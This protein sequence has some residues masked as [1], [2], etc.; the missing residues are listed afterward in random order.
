ME[1]G[2]VSFFHRLTES[3]RP[4]R[5]DRTITPIPEGKRGSQGYEPHR[6]ISGRH[7]LG[8]AFRFAELMRVAKGEIF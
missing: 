2:L 1:G 5:F 8:E 6:E 3:S 4:E 7:E